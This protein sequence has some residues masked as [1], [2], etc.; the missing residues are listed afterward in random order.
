MPFLFK[1]LGRLV[2]WHMEEHMKP[3]HPNQHAFQ[4]GHCTENALSQMADTIE[5]GILRGESALVVFL[6]IKGAFNNLTSS[7]IA[8]GMKK[9]DIH[10]D[11]IAWQKNYLESRYCSV[12]GSEQ[13]FKLVKGTGQGGI[14]SPSLWNFVMD[15][16]LDKYTLAGTA[17]VIDYADDGALVIV[18]RDIGFAQRQMQTAL[19]VAQEWATDVGL[20]FSTAKTK[21]MIFSR[22]KSPPTLPAPLIMG[23]AEVEVVEEFKY[24]GLTMDSRLKWEAHIAHKAKKKKKPSSTS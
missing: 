11:I 4:K 21:A 23:G 7:T 2:K 9:H 6:D 13:I 24:L 1:A 8:N 14:L 18:T 22:K 10:D 20:T 19:D 17:E 16:F 3:F 12:K 5:C 15:S